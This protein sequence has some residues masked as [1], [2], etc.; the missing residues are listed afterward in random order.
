MCVCVEFFPLELKYRSI[1][2]KSE[3]TKHICSDKEYSMSVRD[4]LLRRQ[5]TVQAAASQ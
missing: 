2:G 3:D 1:S 5:I 4:V